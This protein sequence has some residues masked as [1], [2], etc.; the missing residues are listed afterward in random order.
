MYKKFEKPVRTEIYKSVGYDVQS[1]I[2]IL[3]E[4][5]KAYL[6]CYNK[7]SKRGVGVSTYNDKTQWIPKSIWDND[8]YF[9]N[10]HTGQ[11]YFEQP[12]WLK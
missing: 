9:V 1:E 5:E 12:I 11:R 8:K 6:I 3:G 4:T 2:S 10:D 7:P